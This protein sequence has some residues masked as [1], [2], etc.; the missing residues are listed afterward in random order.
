MA[1]ECTTAVTES[2]FRAMASAVQLILVD[3]A[4]GAAEWARARID[5]L[6]GRWSRFVG[7]SELSR[8]VANPG[9]DVQVSSDTLTLVATMVRAHLET[10]GR[11]DPTMLHQLLEAGYDTSID[12]PATGS[13]PTLR[14]VT[15]DRPDPEAGLHRVRMD[16]ARGTV[17]LPMGLGLDPGGIGKGLAADLVV[18][19]LLQRGTRGALVSIGGDLV[20][21]GTAPTGGGWP[22]QIE[23]PTD[24]GA[25]LLE[26]YID[27]G[28]VAT[29]STLSRRWS[30]RGAVAHHVLDP[31]TG[32]VSKTDLATVTAVA[33]TGWQAEVQATAALVSG[34]REAFG[35]L[36]AAGCS[37]VVVTLDGTVETTADLSATAAGGSA[38]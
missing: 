9:H 13:G 35:V 27:G 8:L 37:G 24:T 30:H 4:P 6:E 17:W 20:A 28:A 22:V 5:E 10:A 23:D 32:R 14:S 2:R 25:T 21:A 31:S 26:L 19:E 16:P 11:Y 15:V 33:P 12:E 34:R 18:A 7:D 36:E 29:S 3:P 1:T 38:P